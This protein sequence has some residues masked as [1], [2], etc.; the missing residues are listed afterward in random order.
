LLAVAVELQ[1]AKEILVIVFIPQTVVQV[2]VAV[3]L[4]AEIQITNLHIVL[5]EVAEHR[6]LVGPPALQM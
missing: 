3:E 4:L 6:Y 1:V 5:A 2:V